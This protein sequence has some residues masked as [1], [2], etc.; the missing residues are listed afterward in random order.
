MRV[1][2][3]KH[4]RQQY[5]SNL[6]FYWVFVRSIQQFILE[7][8]RRFRTSERSADP[9]IAIAMYAGEHGGIANEMIVCRVFIVVK[10]VIFWLA[11]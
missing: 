1:S 5:D 2:R 6:R 7:R 10:Y 3:S 9:A 11:F 8:A 4:L